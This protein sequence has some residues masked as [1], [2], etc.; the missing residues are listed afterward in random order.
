VS[1]PILLTGALG[2]I[3]STLARGLAAEH[4]V[5][6]LDAH[7]YAGDPRR[8]EGLSDG[9]VTTVRGDV[10]EDRDVVAVLAAHRPDAIVHFAA[11]SH[12]TRSESDPD[13]FYRTNVAGTRVLFDAAVDAG[14]KRVIHVS[15]DEVY[16]PCSGRPFGE[17]AKGAGV[18]AATS[19]YA[20]SK[21]L[22][23]DIALSYRDRV[24][25][26]VARPTNCFGP[27][28]HPEKAV[29]RWTIRAL[30]RRA[31]P[32]WGDG[33]HVRDWMYVDDACGAIA[34]LL[35]RGRPGLAYNIGPQAGARS[36]RQVATAV[37]EAAGRPSNLVTTS[38]YD[39][40][41]HD[42]RYAVDCSRM[43]ELGWAPTVS[44]DE[45]IARTV[46]W[47]ANHA[48]WWSTML[49]DAEALYAD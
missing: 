11:E 15:T 36:N 14:V 48:D 22:A 34:L 28:Q 32:V 37:A 30:E 35:E 29:A 17:D 16:G 41:Q 40:P 27:W 3:G 21:A 44:F 8:L 19:D 46:V 13:V 43:R 47:Y 12:V 2:F 42:R 49:P 39:R 45:G 4:T 23:D 20:R 5:V 18:G 6:N 1:G 25:V 7:T 38:T 26:I 31:L 9:S 10:A 24:E 33:G